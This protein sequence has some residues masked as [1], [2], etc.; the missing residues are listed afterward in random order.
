MIMKMSN[1]KDKLIKLFCNSRFPTFPLLTVVTVLGIDRTH[2]YLVR[3]TAHQCVLLLINLI[4]DKQ[5][6]KR[7]LTELQIVVFYY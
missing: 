3:V 7:Y 4:N 5:T 1:A 6:G 2:E